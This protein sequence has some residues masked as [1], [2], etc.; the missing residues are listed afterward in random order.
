MKTVR[1]LE[2]YSWPGNIREL[3]NSVNQ[4]LTNSDGPAVEP[5]ELDSKFFRADAEAPAETLPQ[6]KVRHE[7]EELQ[8]I[9]LGLRTARSK[10]DAA[11]RL[12]VSP[13]T[14]HSKMI[15]FGLY[16]EDVAP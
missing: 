12:G 13:N 10:A 1:I 5:A 14:L 11:K 15:K 9:E 7:Q 6:L 8:F 3:E 16:K 2:K 4:L